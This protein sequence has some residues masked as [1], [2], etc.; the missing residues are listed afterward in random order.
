MAK[1]GDLR[2]IDGKGKT[3]LHPR[4]CMAYFVADDGDRDVIP[5]SMQLVAGRTGQ[6][7]NVR[8]GRT[9]AFW[10]DRYHSTAIENGDHLLR[11]I[12]YI[13]LNIVR[14]GV[15][16]HPADCEYSGYNEIQNPRRKCALIAYNRRRPPR[17]TTL[18]REYSL[19]NGEDFPENKTSGAAWA[20]Q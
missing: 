12:V 17:L 14:A 16:N 9:G 6:E 18:C 20:A 15:V 10:E 2:N 7:Y 11:C 5:K 19:D 1:R 8:K 3:T 13:D 4:A